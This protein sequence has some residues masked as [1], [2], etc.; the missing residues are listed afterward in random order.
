MRINIIG[1]DCAVNPADVAIA[2]GR[3]SNGHTV[4]EQI[5]QQKDAVDGRLG[6]ILWAVS[7]KDGTK[8]SERKLDSLP[9]FDGLIAANEKLFLSTTDG[10]V[11]CY[12]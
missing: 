7:T 5:Q 10:R 11:I 4:V 3:F 9:V 12:K 1:I 8:R 6:G 2:F